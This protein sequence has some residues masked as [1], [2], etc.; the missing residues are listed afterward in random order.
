LG[1]HIMQYRAGI[2]GGECTIGAAE[3]GGTLVFC[4]VPLG[5]RFNPVSE[6]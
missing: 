5:R 1:L 6:S 2:L 3:G 4:K